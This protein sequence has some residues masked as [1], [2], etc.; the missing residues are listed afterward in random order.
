MRKQIVKQ[1]VNRDPYGDKKKE[2]DDFLKQVQAD[3]RRLA[4]DPK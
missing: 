2:K 4:G 3:L 1:P